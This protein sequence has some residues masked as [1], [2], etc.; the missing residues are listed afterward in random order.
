MAPEAG[1]GQDERTRARCHGAHASGAGR[2]GPGT[3][4]RAGVQKGHTWGVTWL[5]GGGTTQLLHRTAQ[6]KVCTRGRGGPAHTPRRPG[7]AGTRLGSSGLRVACL[8]G[9]RWILDERWGPAKTG[10]PACWSDASS[11]GEHMGTSAAGAGLGGGLGSKT[12]TTGFRGPVGPGA[13]SPRWGRPGAQSPGGERVEPM[14]ITGWKLP[15]PGGA[16]Q[17]DA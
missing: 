1:T 13:Q 9:H 15:A 2:R 4:R 6:A 10:G 16:G 11:S 12:T 5:R 3:L 14:R 17:A 8:H 7:A